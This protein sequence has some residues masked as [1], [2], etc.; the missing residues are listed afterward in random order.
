[1]F[2]LIE[3][4]PESESN[5]NLKTFY[6][7]GDIKYS[8]RRITDMT[9]IMEWRTWHNDNIDIIPRIKIRGSGVAL[10]QLSKTVIWR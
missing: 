4:Q 6:L 3:N 7:G 8:V 5:E 2:Y 1:M 10:S 9:T